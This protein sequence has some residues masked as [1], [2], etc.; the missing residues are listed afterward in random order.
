MVTVMAKESL[1]V[2]VPPLAYTNPS[3]IDA[4]TNVGVPLALGLKSLV[5]AL[6]FAVI[7]T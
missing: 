7:H 3:G 5:P 6:F 2:M 4:G 1:P